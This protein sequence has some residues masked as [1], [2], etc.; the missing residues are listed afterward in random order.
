M[1]LLVAAGLAAGGW[2]LATRSTGHRALAAH[3]RAPARPAPKPTVM[4]LTFAANSV[5]PHFDAPPAAGVLFDLWTGRT[6][7]KLNVYRRLPIASLTKVMTAIIVVNRT[8]PRDLAP[9]TNEALNYS[10]QGQALGELPPHKRVPVEA[11]LAAMIVT[12]AE[13]AA[14]DLADYVSG[15]DTKFAALM[16]Q[17][18]QNLGLRCSHF[19]SPDGIEPA[20]Q[21]CVADLGALARIAMNSPRIAR[22]AGE[23]QARA[24]FPI[25]GGY[26]YVTTTNPLLL[27]GYP[28][29]IGLKT[30]FTDRA[31]RCLIAVVTRRHRTLVAVLLDSPNPALQ[32]EKLFGAGFALAYIG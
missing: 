19:V 29:T 13:D 15:T 11:L 25:H 28:G 17:T 4:G 12:S 8:S 26:L 16:N 24:R 27:S 10:R 1:V 14:I 22:Y 21:S 6:L 32:A 20:N 2:L 3:R 9:V 23:E 5:A 31:G 7:W 30:G 18:A